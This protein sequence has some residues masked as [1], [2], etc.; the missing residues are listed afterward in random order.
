VTETY[1][2]EPS[3]F[4]KAKAN[5]KLRP[6]DPGSTNDSDGRASKLPRPCKKDCNLLASFLLQPPPS[7]I[8]FTTRRDQTKFAANRRLGPLKTNTV[9]CKSNVI[10]KFVAPSPSPSPIFS[11]S[12][13]SSSA[14]PPHRTSLYICISTYAGSRRSRTSALPANACTLL[15]SRVSPVSEEVNKRRGRAGKV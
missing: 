9:S 3:V 11:A 6:Y 2:R 15:G 7:S 10:P 13:K 5:Y 1:A 4:K 12:K 8:L 14:H